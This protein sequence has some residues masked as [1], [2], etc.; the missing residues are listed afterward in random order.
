ML[1]QNFGGTKKR[2][3]WY[4]WSGQ[5]PL[6]Q[7]YLHLKFV[8]LQFT[9]SSY[10]KKIAISRFRHSCPHGYS[11]VSETDCAWSVINV[12]AREAEYKNFWFINL[13]RLM[14]KSTFSSETISDSWTIQ[15]HS[16]KLSWVRRRTYHELNSLMGYLH[17]KFG[18]WPWPYKIMKRI[19]LFTAI[20]QA[21]A[22]VRLVLHFIPNT[23]ECETGPKANLRSGS[24]FVSL[25][26]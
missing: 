10:N 20:Q 11:F 13:V 9:S 5:L 15:T 17:E 8:F 14:K 4:F 18:V 22:P 25:W 26:K 12:L 3:L 21:W 1:M 6:R 24:I 2:T 16:G 19:L 7:S 23:I